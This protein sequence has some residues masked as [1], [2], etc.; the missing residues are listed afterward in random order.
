MITLLT[1][2]NSF[3]LERALNQLA[4]EFKGEI[5]RVDGEGL[6]LKQLPDLFMGASLFSDARTIFIRDLSSNKVIWPILTKWVNRISDDTHIVL[7]ESKVDKRT[8]TYKALKKNADV[9]EFTSWGARDTLMAEKWTIE[10]AARHGLGLD[11]KIAHQLVEMVGLDQW[12]LFHAIEKLSLIDDISSDIV[13][14]IIERNPSDNAFGLLEMAI[15]GDV[16][17]LQSTLENLKLIDDPYRLFGLLSSQVMNLVIIANSGSNNDASRDFGIHP[18]V[19]SKTKGLAA[20]FSTQ[21]LAKLLDIFVGADTS[22]KTAAIDPWA[23]IENAL[24][25]TSNL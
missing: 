16:L 15:K 4:L 25:K 23:I 13:T 2:D 19:V 14:D 1:G 20:K 3:E 18:F 6:Q 8:A 24:L 21:D 9:R 11:K 17:N 7:I 10:E 22:L 5:E 12:Q